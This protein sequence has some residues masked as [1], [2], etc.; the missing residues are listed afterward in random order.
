[1]IWKEYCSDTQRERERERCGGAKNE[2]CTAWENIIYRN[3]YCFFYRK[4]NPN[5]TAFMKQKN[6]GTDYAKLE[7]YY[8][9]RY[10]CLLTCQTPMAGDLLF[11]MKKQE[12]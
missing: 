3:L 8:V 9:Q 7:E 10:T 12:N 2:M 4:S 6:F 5:I 1:M 11:R